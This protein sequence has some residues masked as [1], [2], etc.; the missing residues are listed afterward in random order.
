M[1]RTAA[2]GRP[3]A[4]LSCGVGS[5][6]QGGDCLRTRA[7]SP[8]KRNAASCEPRLYGRTNGASSRWTTAE[9]LKANP[10]RAPRG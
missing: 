9:R 3:A 2:Y 1:S 10:R 4:C 6:R 8:G 7:G 5:E